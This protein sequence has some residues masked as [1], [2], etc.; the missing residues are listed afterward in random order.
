[1]RSV[2]QLAIKAGMIGED[3]EEY[4]F[5]SLRAETL[6]LRGKVIGLHWMEGCRS[7]QDI[8]SSFEQWDLHATALERAVSNFGMFSYG[9]ELSC[10][11]LQLEI[12]G[13]KG[14]ASDFIRQAT[15]TLLKKVRHLA[16]GY[17]SEAL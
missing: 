12:D 2:R 8:L 16:P 10:C 6:R 9:F 11:M 13:Y 7:S 4:S 17:I 15:Y 5:E 1:M 14:Q 3:Q